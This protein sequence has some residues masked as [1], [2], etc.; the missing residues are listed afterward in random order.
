MILSS[1]SS[2]ATAAR[3]RW[4]TAPST[5]CTAATSSTSGR[6]A[7]WACRCCATSRR[8]ATSAPSIRRCCP[9]TQRAAVIDAIRYIDYV[10]INQIRHRDRP[11]AAAPALLREG[12]RLAR[13]RPA[14][15]AGRHLPRARHRDRL[16]RHRA[17]LVQ[18]PSQAVLRSNRAYD[19]HHRVRGRRPRAEADES[20]H[21]DENYWLGEWRAGD[22]NYS[23]ETRRRIEAKNPRSSRTSSSRS[24]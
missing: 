6:R 8:T 22:N 1:I 9:K 11:A 14:A 24:A 7:S 17:R 4:W 12:E 3:W 5:R 18:P 23:L 10:H 21:Y 20:G 15:R 2:R 16:P 13:A 19:E